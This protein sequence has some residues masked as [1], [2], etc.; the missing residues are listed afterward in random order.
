M[1]W[2]PRHG[3]REQVDGHV[4]IPVIP[5]LGWQ[6]QWFSSFTAI[7]PDMGGRMDSTPQEKLE[8]W[9]PFGGGSGAVDLSSYSIRGRIG[10]EAPESEKS[11]GQCATGCAL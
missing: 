8:S 3:L 10:M 4:P 7:C 5:L 11:V 2:K 6:E 1:C 9:S